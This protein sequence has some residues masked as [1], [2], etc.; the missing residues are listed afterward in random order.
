MVGITR[1]WRQDIDPVIHPGKLGVCRDEEERMHAVVNH[2][3]IKEGAN[4]GELATKLGT[5]VAVTRQS[6]PALLSA[7][8]IRASDTEA[9]LVVIYR[10]R[11]SLDT[12]SKA[13]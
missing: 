11:E 12:I 4:W 10:D 13:I 1:N 2:L 5:F 6:H 7:S 8:V 3:P 9:I